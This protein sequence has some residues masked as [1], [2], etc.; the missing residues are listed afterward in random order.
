MWVP[1]AVRR[2]ANCYTPFTLLYFTLLYSTSH[3]DSLLYSSNESLWFKSFSVTVTV[4]VRRVTQWLSGV[5]CRQPVRW[6]RGT[7]CQH[8]CRRPFLQ[9]FRF[10]PSTQNIPLLGVLMHAAQRLSLARMRHINPRYTLHYVLNAHH[11]G[12][13]SKLIMYLPHS[14]ITVT[15]QSAKWLV[16]ISHPAEGWRLSWPGWPIPVPTGLDVE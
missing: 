1:V 11:T 7:R 4:T 16:H 14:G 8:A 3:A 6:R 9:H 12:V 10:W 15:G 2:V 13:T 5:R